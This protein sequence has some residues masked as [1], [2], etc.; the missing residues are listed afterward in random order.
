LPTYCKGN[1]RVADLTGDGWLDVVFYNPRGHLAVYHGGPRGFSTERMSRIE[2]DLGGDG[3]VA[4]I[5]CADLTGNGWLDLIV[6][7]M[8]HYTRMESGFHILY[9]GPDGYAQD[10]GEYHRTDASSILLTVADVNADGHLDLL[11]PAYSTQFS[12]VLPAHIYWGTP[13]GIDYQHPT[14]IP[15]DS[16]CAFQ[17]VDMT[18]NG[19][20]DVLTVC[21]RTDLGHRVDSLLFH[22]GPEGLDL[23]HPVR[24]PGM[25]PHLSTP[26]DFG[27]AFTREPCE[28]YRSPPYDLAGRRPVRVD[29]IADTPPRTSV[30]L[31]LRWADSREDLATA[32]WHGADGA[33]STFAHPGRVVG[34]G[35]PQRWLQYQA[36]LTSLDGCS[37]PS[38]REV[39]VELA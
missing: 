28:R 9:G 36:T 26:R 38:L 4:A 35:G 10:R 16:S 39:S 14:V 13:G 7:V 27:N 18:G 34:L 12:R 20:R 21:H 6:V 8:G 32:P 1:A 2:L 17:V 31:Q 5:N 25:G 23:D 3:N 37:T 11:V 19:Y 24:L 22:N 33:G 29:W 15:C 30:E